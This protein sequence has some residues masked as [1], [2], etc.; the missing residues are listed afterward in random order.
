MQHSLDPTSVFGLLT[1]LILSQPICVTEASVNRR[2][3]KTAV[4]CHAAVILVLLSLR[5]F[6]QSKV[7]ETGATNILLLKIQHIIVF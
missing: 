5:K 3:D 7:F 6:K 2:R 1:N 4:K